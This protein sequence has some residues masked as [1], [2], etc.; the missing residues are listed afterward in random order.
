[1]LID[2]TP[3]AKPNESPSRFGWHCGKE[4]IPTFLW[5]CAFLLF[6]ALSEKALKYY[7]LSWAIR[8]IA[9]VVPLAF[10]AAMF[11]SAFQLVRNSDEL[12][13]RMYLESLAAA[14][15]GIWIL[16]FMAPILERSGFVGQV[17]SSW[18]L[19]GVALLSLAGMLFSMRR[20]GS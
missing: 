14:A 10:A 5:T 13:R 1:M 17:G 4:A 11:R 12:V 16:G 20:Y 8:V 2:T 15:V 6:A 3:R 7:E 19:H 18:F 9:V